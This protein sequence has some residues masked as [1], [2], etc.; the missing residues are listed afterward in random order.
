MIHL[1]IYIT[2]TEVINIG[3]FSSTVAIKVNSLILQKMEEF[4]YLEKS[5]FSRCMFRKNIGSK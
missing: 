1:S 4:K 3:R 5:V 2:K